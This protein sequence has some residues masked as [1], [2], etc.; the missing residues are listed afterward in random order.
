M[1][2][3]ILL[4]FTLIL[5]LPLFAQLEVKEGSFNEVPGFVNINTEKMYDDNDK[6]YAVLKIKTE[7][8]SSKER[9]EL[10]F[11]GDAQTFFEVE[12]QDGE[13]WL[14]ISYYATYIKISHDEFSSTEFHF[15]F[16]MKPKCGYELTLINKT[17]PISNGWASLTITTSPENGAEIKL[18]GRNLNQTTPY[19]NNM[20]PA[21]KYE[22]TVSKFGFEDV[23]KTIVVDED[24][25]TNLDVEMPYLYSILNIVSEPSGALI[26]IDDVEYGVTPSTIDSIKYGFH[27]LRLK[28]NNYVLYIKQIEVKSKSLGFDAFLKSCPEGAIDGVFSVG[29][30]KQVYFSKGNLQYQASTNTY[31]FAD[32]QWDYIGKDNNNISKNYSGWID[33]FGWGTGNNPT[34]RSYSRDNYMSFTDWGSNNISNGAGRIWS[35]LTY[36]EWV[37]L[38]YTRSKNSSISF[39]KAIVNGVSGVIILP[40]NWN[41]DTYSLIYTNNRDVDFNK[42]RISKNDWTNKLEANGAVFL[43]AAGY[44]WGTSQDVLIEDIGNYGHYWSS[45]CNESHTYEVFFGYNF[46]DVSWKSREYGNSVRLVWYIE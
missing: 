18:N 40:D 39:A 5:S 26:Y 7:N 25:V 12:Y 3:Y 45:S 38:L 16:N 11:K 6:P 36:D 13:I 34:Q 2:E 42:N 28:K 4:L 41:S 17:A 23:T 20:I 37:Y 44:R 8:I 46:L 35:T 31:R 24:Q 15:P 1:K 33:L 9:H 29:D 22:I 27:E 43:P 21:G 10:N 19:T 14:Y 30:N 32:N